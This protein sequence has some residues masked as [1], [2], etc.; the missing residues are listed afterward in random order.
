MNSVHSSETDGEESL[1]FLIE[2]ECWWFPVWKEDL[3]KP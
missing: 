2:N 1:F 3:E